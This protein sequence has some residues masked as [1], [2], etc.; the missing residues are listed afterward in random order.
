MALFD[1][2]NTP[3][4]T[5]SWPQVGQAVAALLSLPV[6]ADKAGIPSLEQF[7]NRHVYIESFTLTQH[8]MLD[9]VMRVTNTTKCDWKIST[10][11]SEAAFKNGWERFQGG[12]RM[13]LAEWMYGRVFF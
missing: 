2:G 13:G 1:D 3:I 8:E 12:D 6:S 9:S 4:T 11:T 7:R 10:K 5:S